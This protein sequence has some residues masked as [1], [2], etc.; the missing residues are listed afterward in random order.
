VKI[1][2]M[3]GKKVYLRGLDLSDLAGNYR[4]WFNDPE[5]CKYNSHG[6]FPK[7]NEEMERYIR[8]IS[9]SSHDLV[10]A[11]VAQENDRHIGNISLQN[12]DWISRSAEYAVILGDRD[13]WGK[14]VAKEASDLIIRH[15]FMELNI[16]RIY[17]G[18]AEDNLPMQKLAAYLGMEKEGVRKEAL[19]KNGKYKDIYE[20]GIVRDKYL[21]SS[22][23]GKR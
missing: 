23:E 17:C 5:V 11:I 14:G 15:G 19:F 10:L 16:H 13:Y 22:G 8:E 6:Y 1:M 18:T 3:K 7:S 12:I 20:Y 9:V 21:A 2:F 4:S